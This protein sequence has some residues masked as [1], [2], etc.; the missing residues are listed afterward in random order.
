DADAVA[1]VFAM[2][3][4]P[5]LPPVPEALPA[6]AVEALDDDGTRELLRARARENVGADVLHRLVIDTAGLPLAIVEVAA[7]LTDEQLA[8]RV[9]L[10]DE[11]PLGPRLEQHFRAQADD[12]DPDSQLLLLLAAAEPTAELAPVRAAAAALAVSPSAEET[13]ARRG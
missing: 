3:D 11:L 6:L 7:A 9:P 5:D 12:L 10:P 8:G 4:G 1:L 13:V 2:R